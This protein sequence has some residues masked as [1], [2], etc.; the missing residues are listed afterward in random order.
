M[1]A[2]NM[3]TDNMQG[4]FMWG[5]VLECEAHIIIH[6]LSMFVTMGVKIVVL[7][8]C[9]SIVTSFTSLASRHALHVTRF[10]RLRKPFNGMGAAAGSR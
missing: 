8:V 2:H 3:Q 6:I 10:T 7:L 5:E 1:H 9:C 4:E